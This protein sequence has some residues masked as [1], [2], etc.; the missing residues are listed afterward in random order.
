MRRKKGEDDIS[1][2][3]NV[4]ILV[5]NMGEKGK[6]GNSVKYIKCYILMINDE[7]FVFLVTRFRGLLLQLTSTRSFFRNK[8]AI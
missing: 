8:N 6:S 3:M 5:Y 4:G 7:S 1:Y 2:N